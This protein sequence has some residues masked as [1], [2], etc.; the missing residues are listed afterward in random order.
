M[1][2][3]NLTPRQILEIKGA[4][5]YLVLS[6]SLGTISV[7]FQA[8]AGV[9]IQNTIS[10]IGFLAFISVITSIIYRRKKALK[11]AL[12]FE[13]ISGIGMLLATMFTKFRYAGTMDW[14]YAAQGYHLA[15]ISVGFIVMTQFLY[16]K[17]LYRVL[18]VAFFVNWAVFLV[19]ASSNGVTFHLQSIVDGTIVHDG[20][21]IH[22]EIYYIILMGIIAF[23]SYRNIPIMED[24]GNK[25][26]KQGDLICRQSE[27]Q[28]GL[29]VEIKR[30]MDDL[31]QRLESQNR[32][33]ETINDSIQS[34]AS[35]FEQVSAAM[36]EL[37]ASADG[38]SSMA[39]NQLGEN[40]KM[41]GIIGEFRQVR[42]ETNRNLD[43]TLDDMGTAVSKTS[44]GHEKI[45][46]VTSTMAEISEQSKRISETVSVIIDIADKINLLSLNASI[47]AARAG[48]YGRGF[49]VVADEIGKLAVQTTDSIKEISSVLNLSSQTTADGV[50]V[51]GDAAVIIRDMIDNI[52][53]SSDKIKLL[54]NSMAREEG[55]IESLIGQMERN[56]EISRSIDQGTTEQKQAITGSNTAIEQVNG[57]ITGMADAVNNLAAL[58]KNIFDDAKLILDKSTEAAE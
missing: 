53:A 54:K 12:V 45:G 23:I 43:L 20:L 26:Q 9:N 31:F 17:N 42:E 13:W 14:T 34:Q 56:I 46:A 29:T 7:V 44:T 24:Y 10:T 58:S 47:E 38:I 30:R 28:H 48:D 49:A 55:Q 8:L 57:V 22:R 51:I 32:S 11:P 33:V 36:E 25:Y 18:A 52:A 21:Q 41:D 35:T 5:L 1:D 39:V 27:L 19:F 15:A 50:R 16:N 37:L 4:F 3:S 6:I 2:T 40:R